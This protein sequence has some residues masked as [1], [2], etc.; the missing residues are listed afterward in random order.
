M[1]TGNPEQGWAKAS[2]MLGAGDRPLVEESTHRAVVLPNDGISEGFPGSGGGRLVLS[3][4]CH[5]P[6]VIYIRDSSTLT[7]SL[8]GRGRGVSGSGNSDG[9]ADQ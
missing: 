7:L 4:G 8:V 9:S 6:K 3:S 5:S 2:E 1:S